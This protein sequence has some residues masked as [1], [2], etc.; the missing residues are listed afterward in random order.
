M[1]GMCTLPQRQVHALLA[2]VVVWLRHV[3]NIFLILSGQNHCVFMRET[4]FLQRLIISTNQSSKLADT[5]NKFFKICQFV[6]FLL[7][8][9]ARKQANGWLYWRRIEKTPPLKTACKI[10]ATVRRPV[11]ALLGA[12]LNWHACIWD[13]LHTSIIP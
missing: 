12:F 7:P 9:P 11:Q 4:A 6:Q 2:C 5:L 10:G 3:E 1:I 13:N 8:P